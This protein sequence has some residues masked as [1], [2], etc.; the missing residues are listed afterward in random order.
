[1][2]KGIEIFKA[3]FEGQKDSYVIVGGTACSLLLEN[4]GLGFRVTKDIDIVLHVGVIKS[5]FGRVFWKFVKKGGYQGAV[6]KS[7]GKK[8]FYRFNEP[9]VSGYPDMIELFA[10]NPGSFAPGEAARFMKVPFGEGVDGLSAILM[11]GE[12]YKLLQTGTGILDGLPL[13][14]AE[15][16]IPMKA[17]AFLNLDEWRRGGGKVQSDDIHKHKRDVFRLHQ[18][19]TPEM[20]PI[21]PGPIKRDLIE[22]L[23]EVV[24]NP[25]EPKSFG[26]EISQEKVI[27]DLRTI[28]GLE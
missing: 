11:D 24:K 12:Y 21:M 9:E 16:L 27:G 14:K 7:S 20:R 4:E 18:L 1:L 22:F 2:I 15:Y 26:L 25:V 28:Y 3:H 10:P 13:L 5:E 6:K 19:L 8:T 17:K 23:D